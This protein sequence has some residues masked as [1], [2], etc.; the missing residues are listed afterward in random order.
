MSPDQFGNFKGI[1][2]PRIPWHAD[3]EPKPCTY[4]LCRCVTKD[5]CQQKHAAYVADRRAQDQGNF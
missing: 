1:S 5:K 2:I 4:P 3:P